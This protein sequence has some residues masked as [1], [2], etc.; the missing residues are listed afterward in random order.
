MRT[1]AVVG[2]DAVVA[3]RTDD[4]GEE[5]GSEVDTVVGWEDGVVV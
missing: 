3:V 2:V 5:G 4:G 1:Y